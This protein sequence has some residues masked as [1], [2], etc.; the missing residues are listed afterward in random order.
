ML[1]PNRETSAD[2]VLRSERREALREA[3]IE[4]D[5]WEKID[6]WLYLKVLRLTDYIDK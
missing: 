4:D 1:H 2:G 5:G 3:Y 6:G